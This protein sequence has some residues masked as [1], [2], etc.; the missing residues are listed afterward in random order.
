MTAYLIQFKHTVYCQGRDDVT[1]MR[2]VY[3]VTFHEATL[4]LK[5]VYKSATDF[6]NLTIQ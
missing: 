4:K 2:I 6:V 5:R 1:E 3:A